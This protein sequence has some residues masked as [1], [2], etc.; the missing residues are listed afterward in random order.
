MPDF[1]RY[2]LPRTAIPRRYDLVLR[3]DLGQATFTGSVTIE[4]DVHE[5]ISELVLNAVDLEIHAATAHN[6]PE[7]HD[8][9]GP[10]LAATAV[11]D[12]ETERVTLELDGRLDTGPALV[13]IEFTGQFN[14]K[15]VGF[16]RSTFT[17]DDGREQTI[18]TTQFESTHAR[19]AFP[20]WDEPDLKATF[21]LTLEVADDLLAVA[22]GPEETVTYL[23]NGR[24]AIRFEETP[25]ISTY[26]VAFVVGP[27]E[28]TDPV[29]VDGIPLRIVHVPGKGH[30][31]PFALD[32]GAFALRH[33][34][35]FFAI[36]YPFGKCDMIALPDFAFGAMENIGC[37][38]FREVLL[39][40]DE[41]TAT[42]PEME[43]AADVISHELAHM[44]FG[45]LVTMRWWN[46]IWLKEAFATFMEMHTV[47]GWKPD[48]DRW[49][50]FGLSRS[51]AFTIDELA[52]TRPVE[53]DVISPDEAEGMY[54]VLTYEK[55]AAVVRM[56]EQYLTPEVF[57]EGCRHYMATHAYGNTE[58]DDL[59]GSLEHAS[60]QPIRRVMASW[61]FQG[62]FPVVS[63]R[64]APDR[65]SIE[66]HQ[67]RYH[68]AGTEVAE[69]QWAVPI[70]VRAS[71]GGTM[72]TER[73]LLDTDS[74][75][76]TVDSA[77]DH[78]DIDWAIVNA[79]GSGWYRVTYDD[80]LTSGLTEAMTTLDPVERYGL[81]DDGWAAVL[82]GERTMAQ[83]LDL[84][85]QFRH[86]NDLSVW[87]RIAA[88][89]DTVDRL[90][91]DDGA[92]VVLAGRVRDLTQPMTVR[93]GPDVRPDDDERTREIR[94]LLLRLGG[95][96]GRDTAAIERSRA[97]HAE[98]PGAPPELAAAAVDVIASHGD[99][100]D[101][102]GFLTNYR[103]APT[104]QEQ[105][106]NLYALT[107]FPGI[108]QIDELLSLLDR[109]EVRSQNAPYVLAAAM[110]NRGHG[111]HVWQWVRMNWENLLDR[112][113]SNSV[114]RMV[115][116]I[117]A[118]TRPE[119]AADIKGF[120]SEHPIP[121]GQL[122]LDQHLERLE[123]LSRLR[124]DEGAELAAA[125]KA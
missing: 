64:L 59:W 68:H 30:L 105:L 11:F 75:T 66:L 93:L 24:R 90:L 88:G 111:A 26:L 38:T 60:G 73:V 102:A 8:Q 107:R 53:F 10:E 78:A 125:L 55:G 69:A 31:T 92:R 42:Q 101:F 94:A 29:D 21:G 47:D 41:D 85:H 35:D 37:V 9:P 13:H 22:N 113:P 77:D 34:A 97:I 45:N 32:I 4:L 104:P 40:V 63:A 91:D 25:L 18:A 86:D 117:T 16:Y 50:S 103:E 15:L 57:R 81:I 87:Q 61:I 56:I 74:A 118:L 12:D 79:G 58:T 46:G 82:A 28:V 106:R 120:F 72:T 76:I 119:E 20:C 71:R 80:A 122:T 89:L 84:V 54:D 116:G 5:P 36:D 100:N 43:R 3:P 17:D 114:V 99:Q 83:F 6:R 49:V 39:L 1:S 123:V 70:V 109:E 67:R 110:R 98:A 33:L 121:Q 115:S 96:L 51:A 14:D 112:Y 48:W 44:W 7:A 27:L 95:D 23:G 65:R 108:E 2:R 52:S 62:G 124:S 19:R